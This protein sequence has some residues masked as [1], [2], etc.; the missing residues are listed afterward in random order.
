MSRLSGEQ[1]K[2]ILL[3]VQALVTANKG[4]Q[5]AEVFSNLHKDEDLLADQLAAWGDKVR[6][7]EQ[8]LR[9]CLDQM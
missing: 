4:F 8:G 1:K 3:Y 7:A 6:A 5:V 9:N 2:L